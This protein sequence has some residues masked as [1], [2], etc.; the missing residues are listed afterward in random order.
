[1]KMN[2]RNSDKVYVIA[3]A[4]SNFDGKLEQAKQLIE[5]AAEAGADAVKFQLFNADVLYPDVT[6]PVHARVRDCE[7]P[8]LWLNELKVYAGDCGIDFLATP[9]DSDAVD[10]LER[11]GV[12]AYKWGS[13]ETVNHRLLLKVAR[14][15]KPV[16][17]S[18]GMCT[19]ADIAEAVEI[20]DNNGCPS[21][22]IL[23]CVAV[24]PTEY[25][26]AHLRVMQTLQNAFGKAVGFSDHSLGIALPIAAVALGANVIEKHFTISRVLK[27]PDHFYAL[28]PRELKDMVTH[29]RS[30]EAAMGLSSKKMHVDEKSWG[31]RDGIYA[32]RSMKRGDSIC[33][34]DLLIKRPAISIP[35]RYQISIV[36][37]A[38]LRDIAEGEPINWIDIE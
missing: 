7:L 3:E 28:E 32:K 9:F 25:H 6:Q 2:E 1:M 12:K 20:L 10:Q 15:G 8:R 14:T 5:V 16:Y 29:I 4:G 37:A 22:T 31:R 27:G 21:I 36:G 38:L 23:H 30:V 19:M 11:E 17:L 33:S 13:S 34:D 26:D 24:Y 18:T 35:S